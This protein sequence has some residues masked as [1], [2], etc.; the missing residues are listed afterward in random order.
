MVT[1]CPEERDRINNTKKAIEL[2]LSGQLSTLSVLEPKKYLDLD[3]YNKYLY[4]GKKMY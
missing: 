1:P 4:Q 2:G 3:I